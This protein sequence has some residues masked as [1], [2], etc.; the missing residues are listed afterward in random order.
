MFLRDM[1]FH[2][3]TKKMFILHRLQRA[4]SQ[5]SK[6]LAR[7]QPNLLE[8]TQDEEELNSW[9]SHTENTTKTAPRLSH[10]VSN[11]NLLDDSLDKVKESEE[12]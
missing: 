12:E 8:I 4:Y 10:S 9:T 6:A 1:I 7:S 5:S 2:V 3:S 11:P